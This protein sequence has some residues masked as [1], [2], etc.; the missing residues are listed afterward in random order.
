MMST[1]KE[2]GFY[3]PAE[4][5]PHAATWMAWAGVS[6]AYREATQGQELAFQQAQKA[7]AEVAAEIARFET[8]KMIVNKAFV[9]DY[10]NS[11][12]AL[13]IISSSLTITSS[14][15]GFFRGDAR[16]SS[17]RSLARS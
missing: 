9:G 5:H 12:S 11:L 13:R 16:I 14:G 1:L 17:T 10:F 3:M 6:E 8:I 7:Y 4:W 2:E 15:R